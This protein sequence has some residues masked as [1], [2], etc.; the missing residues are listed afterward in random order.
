MSVS[1]KLKWR[2]ALSTLKFSYEELNYAQEVSREAAGE[3][4]AYYRKF[5]AEK[6]VNISELDRQH[7][8]RLDALYGRNQ[9]ADDETQDNSDVYGPQESALVVH[10]GFS[11]VDEEYQMTADDIAIHQAFHRLYKQVALMIHPDKI[12]PSL[13]AQEKESRINM[14][15]EAKKSYEDR[16]Y[17]RLLE[18]SEYLKI[19]TSRNYDLQTRWMKRETETIVNLT[20]KEKNT[21]NYYF[22]I[23]ETDEEKENLIRKFLQQLFRMSVQ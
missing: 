2:R 12:E 6:G 13:S 1:K 18:I 16:K 4:E 22:G 3:F 15:A 7:K 19:S 11:E 9:I 23:A 17:Y 21:Y 14:F 10:N 20:T 5:C 8:E